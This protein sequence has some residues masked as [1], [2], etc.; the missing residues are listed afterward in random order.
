MLPRECSNASTRAYSSAA[1]K[2]LISLTRCPPGSASVITS[3]CS[4]GTKCCV[5]K[6]VTGSFVVT[7]RTAES[8]KISLRKHPG[9][10][11]D[12]SIARRTACE[13]DSSKGVLKSAR[14]LFFA[15]PQPIDEHESKTI[16]LVDFSCLSDQFLQQVLRQG[17]ASRD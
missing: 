13:G 5:L 7:T 2:P 11:K 14:H 1:G 17:F 9:F 10:T 6:T 12:Q 15:H 8:R 16:L 3:R 4:V